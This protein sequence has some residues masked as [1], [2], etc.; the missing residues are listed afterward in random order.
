MAKVLFSKMEQFSNE[1]T[2]MN[3]KFK[4]ML[5]LVPIQSFTML[6][7][8]RMVMVS[9]SVTS[10]PRYVSKSTPH[11]RR[12]WVNQKHQNIIKDIH[13]SNCKEYVSSIDKNWPD[14]T[15]AE[16]KI[17][18]S[19]VKIDESEKIDQFEPSWTVMYN[20]VN[21]RWLSMIWNH[22]YFSHRKWPAQM[23]I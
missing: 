10:M 22:W 9:V 4:I 20:K 3:V 15:A 21:G 13:T 1:L 5:L 19:V 18:W 12:N 7:F 23:K 8:V 17:K 14:A 6:L 2:M 11:W 16:A